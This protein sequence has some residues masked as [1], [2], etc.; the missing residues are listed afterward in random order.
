MHTLPMSFRRCILTFTQYSQSRSIDLHITARDFLRTCAT[1]QLSS[2][3]SIRTKLPISNETTCPPPPDFP[4]KKNST[5]YLDLVLNLTGAFLQIFVILREKEKI[6]SKYLCIFFLL[7]TFLAR[8]P[9]AQL[10]G[11]ASLRVNLIYIIQFALH[12]FTRS[13]THALFNTRA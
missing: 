12:G 13:S 10:L 4:C 11:S 5:Q 3:P 1:Q 6:E 9:A 8:T 7:S 2:G